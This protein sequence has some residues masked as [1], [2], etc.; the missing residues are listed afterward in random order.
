MDLLT[1]K[2]D[3]GLDD[4][5]WPILTYGAQRLPAHVLAGARIEDS[6]LSPGC[7]VA[8]SVRRSVLGP[9]VYIA[10]HAVV[11]DSILLHGARIE[12]GARVIRGIIDGNA[13]VGV[14]AEVGGEAEPTVVGNGARVLSNTTVAAGQHVEPA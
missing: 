10:T 2:A 4:P 13:T 8:G 7:T 9:D 5:A 3:L 12:A 6:L 14:R 1:S 11:E